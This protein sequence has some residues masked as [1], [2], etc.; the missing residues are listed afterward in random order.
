MRDLR[1]RVDAGVGPAR[2]VEL[3][4]AASRDLADRAVDLALH[5]ACV[6]LDLPAAV[7]RAGVLD[8]QLESRHQ[9]SAFSA[10]AIRAATRRGTNR[11]L[12]APILFAT[13]GI[14]SAFP[15]I[16]AS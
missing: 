4:L 9:R 8:D 6:L 10:P 5:G 11:T 3:E 2:A 15:A 12:C 1:E 13:P 7:A 16:I 14:A